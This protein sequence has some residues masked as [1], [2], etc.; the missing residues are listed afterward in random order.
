[1]SDAAYIA[2]NINKVKMDA[3]PLFSYYLMLIECQLTVAVK[4]ILIII[5][6][7]LIIQIFWNVDAFK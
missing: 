4:Y 7:W 2:Y 3:V 1:M 6:F 5:L